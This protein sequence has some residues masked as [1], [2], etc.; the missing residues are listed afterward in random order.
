[1]EHVWCALKLKRSRKTT[2]SSP[3]KEAALFSSL[4]VHALASGMCVLASVSPW[5]MYVFGTQ[6]TE[7][8]H[9]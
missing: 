2:R 8:R 4:I 3:F 9:R 5:R 1:M 6:N 7:E